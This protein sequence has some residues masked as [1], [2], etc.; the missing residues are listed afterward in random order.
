[1]WQNN[2]WIGLTENIRKGKNKEEK[3]FTNKNY[4]FWK[5]FLAGKIS[6][7]EIMD[8]ISSAGP[9]VGLGHRD[10]GTQGHRDTGTLGQLMNDREVTLDLNEAAPDCVLWLKSTGARTSGAENLWCVNTRM[11]LS[12]NCTELRLL[13]KSYP[14]KTDL[15]TNLLPSQRAKSQSKV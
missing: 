5:I 6:S 3:H 2:N 10:T 9:E 7:E 14:R 4:G 12:L 1:M 11:S 15:K 8:F 13:F